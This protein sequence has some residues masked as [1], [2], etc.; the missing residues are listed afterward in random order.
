MVCLKVNTPPVAHARLVNGNRV[1]KDVDGTD[2]RAGGLCDEIADLLDD[3]RGNGADVH[4]LVHHDVQVDGN[5]IVI[6][7]RDAHA[8]AH[9][10]LA[11]QMDKPV[12]HG[13]DRHALDAEA[14]RCRIACNIGIDR[15]VNS[16]GAFFRFQPDHNR[17]SLFAR[18][19]T[20][21]VERGYAR[22]R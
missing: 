17:T 18:D 10:L 16:N 4:A 7:E 20:L 21:R 12:G 3:G 5:G 2:L 13:P 11:Q 6:L 9:C 8:L 1:N 22:W 14:V 19:Q 15:I